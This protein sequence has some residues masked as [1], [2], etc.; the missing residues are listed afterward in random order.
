MTARKI[1]VT[2]A[3]PYANGHI[4]LG[5]LVEYIQTDIWV[6]FQKLRGHRCIYLCADDTHGT[7]IMIRARQE[8]RSEEALIADMREQHMSRLRRL[9]HRVRQ[10]RQHEQRREPRAVRRDLGGAARGRPDRRA[11]RDAA[12]RSGGRHVSG[13]SVRERNLPRVQI[14]RSVWRQLRQVRLDLQPDR[15]DR[16]G[17]H[18]CPARRPNCARRRICSSNIE[19]LHEFLDEWTQI[20]RSPAD[21][22]RQLSE[23]ALPRRAAARLGCFAAGAVFRLRDSRQP[24]QLL[25]RLVRRADRLHG[26]DCRSG[27]SSTAR[28]STTGGAVAE[29]TRDSSLHRQGH[30]VFPHAVL[31]R[32]AEDGRLQPADEGAH[33]R[34]SHRRRR[35]DV[36]DA[37]ARSSAPRRISKHLD[38]AYLR[39]YYAWKLEPALDDLD[40]NLDEFVAK[41]NSDLVG[42]VVNLA[43]RTARSCE[44][45][46]LSA[47]LSRRRRT[48]R[49][50]GRRGRSDRRGLRSLRLQPGHA[51]DHGAGRSG[52]SV[53]RHERAVEAAQRAGSGPRS[54]KMSARSR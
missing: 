13:R 50:G 36:E 46:G 52:E 9:S 34:L 38:P 24:R 15:S 47:T 54:C 51:A 48:V 1:L 6:R 49:R 40:L 7:A 30:H 42:K 44:A 11:R 37:R 2:A 31:A 10:L 14:A 17:Q 45:T 20:G 16:S 5:H 12:L 19:Q 53:R 3:L 28:S 35:E 43:S 26:L 25:V 33:P 21:G 22:S 41:V 18:A 23:G 32:H 4:H 39:Y 29:A 27:A 8:G